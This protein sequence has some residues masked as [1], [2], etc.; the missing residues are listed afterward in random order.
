VTYRIDEPIAHHA[1]AIAAQR[2]NAASEWLRQRYIESGPWLGTT[3]ED[4]ADELVA[5]WRADTRRMLDNSQW[6]E[7]H[8]RWV[9]RMSAL[10]PLANRPELS[11]REIR[12]FLESRG[13]TVTPN[14]LIA[15]QQ[16]WMI[17]ALRAAGPTGAAYVHATER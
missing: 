2:L 1:C 11:G 9:T 10:F 4:L 17:D 3:A 6:A 7:W 5:R 14:Q 12:A 16:A 8:R 15:L 13:V